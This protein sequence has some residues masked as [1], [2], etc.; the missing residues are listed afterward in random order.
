[1]RGLKSG[2]PKP[3]VSEPETAYPELGNAH[4]GQ[5]GTGSSSV[6]LWPFRFHSVFLTS[7]I[8]SLRFRIWGLQVRGNRVH[9][10]G[11]DV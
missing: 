7:R 9:G 2:S 3:R 4:F 6:S 11:F 10:S 1:M 8:Q 5:P